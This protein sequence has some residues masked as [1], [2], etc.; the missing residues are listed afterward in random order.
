MMLVI[1]KID[2]ST[3]KRLK[4]TSTLIYY[5]ITILNKFE[6]EFFGFA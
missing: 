5:T 6:L 4:L 3:F 2:I 1:I